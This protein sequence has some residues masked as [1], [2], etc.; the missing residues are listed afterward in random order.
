M[1][2]QRLVDM[3]TFPAP[4]SS[5]SLTSHLDELFFIHDPDPPDPVHGSIPPI[6][7]MYIPSPNRRSLYTLVHTHSNG[8]DMGD[9]V[10]A[11]RGLSTALSVDSFLIEY[12]GYGL[13]ELHFK[14]MHC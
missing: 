13:Y 14:T 4:S 5:Y 9:M 3:I 1:G 2:L 10:T 6:P 7:C 12:P 8:C 11:M